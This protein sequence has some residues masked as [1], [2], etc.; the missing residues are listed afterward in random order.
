M[1]VPG[2]MFNINSLSNGT[3]KDGCLDIGK[4]DARVP[5]EDDQLQSQSSTPDAKTSVAKYGP[6]LMQ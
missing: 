4:K 6:Q 2:D 1:D 3:Y 5:T